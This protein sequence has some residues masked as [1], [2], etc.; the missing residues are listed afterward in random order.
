MWEI[1]Q[2]CLGSLFEHLQD[3]LNWLDIFGQ[4]IYLMCGILYFCDADVEYWTSVLFII[5]IGFIL[6]RGVITLFKL[7]QSTRYLM[8]MIVDVMK[9]LVPFIIVL[10]G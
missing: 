7:H 10:F 2:I 6:L 1:A 4:S 3:I 5:A 9:G 8:K